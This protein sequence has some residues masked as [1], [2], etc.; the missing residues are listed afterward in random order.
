MFSSRVVKPHS[1]S[2]TVHDSHSSYFH[3]YYLLIT[4][5]LEPFLLYS[6]IECINFI[7]HTF[8]Y[9]N[10]LFTDILTIDLFSF[11]LGT[12]K[13]TTLKGELNNFRFLSH[14]HQKMDNL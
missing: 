9:T 6:L 7:L 14:A 5:P 1:P 4:S 13:N 12:N 11:I 3:T 2:L 8:Y 10:N